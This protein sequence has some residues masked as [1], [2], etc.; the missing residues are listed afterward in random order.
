RNGNSQD[1]RRGRHPGRRRTASK[2]LSHGRCAVARPSARLSI[3][4][5]ADIPAPSVARPSGITSLVFEEN[6]G[7]ITGFLGVVPRPMSFNGRPVRAAISSQFIVAPARRST[8]AAVKLLQAFVSGPQDLSIADEANDASRKL[9]GSL[10][11][12]TALLYSL[13]W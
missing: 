12:S 7:E 13:Y 8:L 6:S 1:I 2:S 5:D 3:L 4:L 11:G 9:L 10:G